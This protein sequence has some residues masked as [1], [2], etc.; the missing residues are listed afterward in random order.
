MSINLKGK[1]FLTV[2]DLSKEEYLQL[3]DIAI[4][5]KNERIM[6]KAHP[7]LQ[8][9]TLA[10]IFQKP[11]LRT[12]VSFE[13]GMLQLGGNAIYLGP[14]EI[15]IG[16]RETTE[17]IA[18]VLSRY[19]DGIMARVFGHNIVEDLAKYAPVP[20]IN[21]LSD[22]T[23]PCQAVADL[24]TVKEKLGKTC[25]FTMTYVGDGNNVANSLAFSAAVLGYDFRIA[26]PKGY[27]L[28]EKVV[29]LAN[30]RIEKMGVGSIEQFESPAKAAEGAHVLY[31]DVWASMGQEDEAEKRKKAFKGY[32][33]NMKLLEKCDKNCI[34]LH[35]LPA[36]YGDEIT[37]DVV[38]SEHSAVFD[39][40]ENRLH[41][42]KALMACLIR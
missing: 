34:V 25:G 32:Q 1:D 6:G 33:I 42:Q 7:I 27:Q 14:N 2:M 8:G 4:Q 17:D 5:L 21:G 31:T 28:D 3:I 9:K 36:H 13:T 22:Y 35:C 11:S 23:H 40:A 12:R 39:Q 19:V 15:G 26:A 16:K 29:K 18:I 37:K 20:V 24:M 30:K 38:D 10:M 41:A